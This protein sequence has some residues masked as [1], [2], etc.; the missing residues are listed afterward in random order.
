[1]LKKLL[2]YDLRSV[3]KYW[4]LAAISSLIFALIGSGCIGILNS[5]RSL[6]EVV[7]VS[8]MLI[9]VLVYMSFVVFLFVSIIFVFLRFYKNFFTDEGYLTFTL[10][11]KRGQLLNSKLIT[12]AV[13]IILTYIVCAVNILTM[14][15]I[16]FAKDVFTQEFW[17]RVKDVWTAL[18]EYFGAYIG[19]Y[20]LELI[21][22]VILCTIFSCLFLFCCVTFASI[23][24]KKAKVITAIGIYYGATTIFSFVTE[25]FFLFAMPSLTNWI[26]Y[27]PTIENFLIAFIMLGVIFFVAILCMILY[28]LQYWMLD[29]KLNLN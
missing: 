17:N 8:V 14:L 2:K 3:F 1:M 16:G 6:P 19:I 23:I 22:I 28:I 18:A 15:C 27:F 13:A 29:R 26:A 9:L 7:N 11:V 25:I 21:V 5:D 10:P 24:T 4:W 12:S 20:I